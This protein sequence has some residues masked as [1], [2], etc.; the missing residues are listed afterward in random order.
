MTATIKKT[1]MEIENLSGLF[2]SLRDEKFNTKFSFFI[3]RNISY[4]KDEIVVLNEIRNRLH[5]SIKVYDS[6]RTSL[7][8]KLSD[9]DEDGNPIIING[10]FKISKNMET[11]NDE[12]IKLQEH[13]NDSVELS[14]V[15][16][17][18][19]NELLNEEI[20]QSI[21][22]VSYLDF[23]EEKFTVEQ[24]YKF[25]DFFKETDEEIEKMIME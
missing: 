22:K 3:L 6:E 23:P 15:L 12:M 5:E 16:Q 2:S 1:R 9:K 25:K 18:E 7:A 20:E 4:M 11:F 10:A 17:E 24:L 21:M 19:L 8:S 14:M 13:H